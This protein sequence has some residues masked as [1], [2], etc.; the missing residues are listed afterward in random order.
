MHLR[1][2]DCD[3]VFDIRSYERVLDDFFTI[4]SQS[5]LKLVDVAVLVCF[6]QVRHG[7]NFWICPIRLCLLR[8]EWIDVALHQHTC[9]HEVLET[10]DPVCIACILPSDRPCRGLAE[11]VQEGCAIPSLP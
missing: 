9:Q 5:S 7:L 2:Q 6:N 8:I 4:C 10:L 1:P 3:E 11:H